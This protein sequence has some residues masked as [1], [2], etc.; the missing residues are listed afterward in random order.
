M[1]SGS[2]RRAPFLRIW[3]NRHDILINPDA[4]VVGC[5]GY[6]V[7]LDRIDERVHVHAV[8]LLFDLALSTR[9]VSDRSIS[10]VLAHLGNI[11]NH[12]AFEL[13]HLFI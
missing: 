2:A 9:I 8:K 4:T 12:L 3:Q 11:L 7:L 10:S 6:D 5:M 13:M 1:W